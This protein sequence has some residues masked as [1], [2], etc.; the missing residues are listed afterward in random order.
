[1]FLPS[2]NQSE[3]IQ[4]I[5]NIENFLDGNINSFPNLN[6]RKSNKIVEK[7]N[8]LTNKLYKR[9]QEELKIYAEIMLVVEK[10]ANGDIKDKINYTNSSNKK[11]NYIAK[12]VNE[13]VDTL[14]QLL[15]NDMNQIV[16]VLDA[17]THKDFT[18][19]VENENAKLVKILNEV[20]ELV[21]TI[22][23]E[24]KSNGISLDKSSNILLSN[25]DKLNITSNE[26][27]ASLEQTAAAVEQITSNIKNTTENIAKMSDFSHE[28]TK[29]VK[30][31][32]ELANKTTTAMEEIN[33]QVNLITEAISVIDQIAFQTNI[34]SLNA[35]VEAATAG[36][37]GLGFAVVAQEVRNLAFRS[38]D[39]AREIKNI[40]ENANSKAL[41]GKN[42]ANDMINGYRGLNKNIQQ[43][44]DLI[45]DVEMSSKEQLSG[46]EQINIAINHL[47][48][49]TQEN[50]MIATQTHDVAVL[51]DDIAKLVISNADE[52][53]FIGKNN[54]KSKI[55]ED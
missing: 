10:L 23:R 44:I 50:A 55:I 19:K 26:T 15:G 13:L 37:A 54:V 31:G 30:E 42:I 7:L 43:T 1:M 5:D 45:S 12:T 35:A 29:A 21:S 40:V 46:I 28:V 34:L 41:Y 25:V 52:I 51:T 20:T 6:T 17:Y 32:E 36:E 48:R 4:I 39:A 22:L 27:A 24:N 38:A 33:V 14:G 8:N 11:L 49:Q 47:D 16:E 53:D 2:S 3:I 18:K 9:H